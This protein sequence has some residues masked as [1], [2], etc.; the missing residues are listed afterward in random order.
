MNILSKMFSQHYIAKCGHTTKLKDKLHAF[1]ESCTCEI[2]QKDKNSVEYC[3]RCLEK[4]T[5]V[6]AWCGKPIFIG[7]P[8]TLYSPDKKEEFKLKEHA[9]VYNE[10]K[11]QVVGCLRWNCADTGGDRAGF[12]MPPGIVQRV[13]TAFEMLISTGATAMIC[14]DVSDPNSKIEVIK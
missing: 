6:C 10:E 7:D 11:M 13:P 4:M 12:W 3:H 5:I 8:I 14:H 1:D 9:V 2:L